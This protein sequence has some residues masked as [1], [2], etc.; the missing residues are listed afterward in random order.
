MT[1][2]ASLGA[3]GESYAVKYLRKAG[4]AVIARNWRNG[5]D[6]LDI[7]ASNGDMLVFIEV[8]TRTV[9][10][11][12][13]DDTGRGYYSVDLRKKRA[14]QRACRAYMSGLRYP[15]A[16]FRF[17]IIEV[18]I[19]KNASYELQHH[20]GVPLFTKQFRPCSHA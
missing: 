15:P 11:G 7:V 5:R 19:H 20:Q 3:R 12:T 14:L 18:K 1:E 16:H 6:E 17:D 10:G 13:V 9:V 8:K 4:Y 2:K